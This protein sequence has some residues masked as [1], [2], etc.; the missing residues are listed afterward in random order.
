M[1]YQYVGK[2]HWLPIAGGSAQKLEAGAI[3]E[4]TERQAKAFGKKFVPVPEEPVATDVPTE[5][6]VKAQAQADTRGDDLIDQ[7]RAATFEARATIEEMRRLEVL[8]PK[9]EGGRVG[10]LKAIDEKLAEFAQ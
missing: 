2:K 8:N 10:V 3:V 4:L 7:V 5:D 6:Q 9:K 1:R